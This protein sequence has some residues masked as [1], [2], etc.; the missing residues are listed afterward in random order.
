MNRWYRSRIPEGKSG[1]WEVKKFTL[2]KDDLK[3]D[4]E[5]R[6]T[7]RQAVPGEYTKL[8]RGGE[9]IMSDTPAEI[10][11]HNELEDYKGTV[12][13]H[14]LGLG[15]AVELL[16]MQKEVTHV[17]VIEQSPDV[18]ALV[19]RTL[20]ERWGKKRLAILHG[21]AFQWKPKGARFDH[22]WSDI[23]DAICSDNLPEM[24]RLRMMWARRTR[25]HGFWCRMEC[26]LARQR[27]RRTEAFYGA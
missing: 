3:F 4:F 13:V 27:D 19:E 25:Q 15:V 1:N 5:N 21:D 2:T 8:T 22:V 23:W 7:G 10:R 18:L 16:L 12:L 9:V 17:T 24:R 14:G 20:T 11:D 26:L 6:A